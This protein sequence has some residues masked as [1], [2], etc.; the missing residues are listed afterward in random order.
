MVAYVNRIDA[1]L[2]KNP[3]TETTVLTR[4]IDLVDSFRITSGEHL[5][6]FAGRDRSEWGYMSTCRL[7]GGGNTKSYKYPARLTVIAPKGTP[8]AAIENLSL[9][10]DQAEVLLGRG[11]RYLVVPR[12]AKCD[13]ST[14][15]WRATIVIAKQQEVAR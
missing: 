3:L 4:T 14:A 13:H 6:R 2:A 9:F 12:S 5:E 15:M 11:L 8:A 10:P 1:V 7:A